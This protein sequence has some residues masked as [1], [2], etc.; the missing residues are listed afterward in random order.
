MAPSTIAR[1]TWVRPPKLRPGDRVRVIAPAGPVPRGPLEAGVAE[2]A[3]LG[4]VAEFDDSLFDRRLIFAGTDARRR[5][6]CERAFADPEARAVFAARGGGGTARI[7]P[8]DAL[9]ALRDRPRAFSGF[10]DLTILHQAMAA[11][12]LVS[13]YGPMVAWD[14]ARAEGAAG[15]Y[16]EALFRRLLLD[17]EPGGPIAPAGIEFL[18]GGAAEGRLAGGCLS[19]L[20][21][22]VGTP[23]SPVFDGAVVVLE[24]ENEYPHRVDRFLHHLRRAGAFRGACA[25]ILGDFPGCEP[26]PGTGMT[27][28]DVLLDFFADFEGPVAWGF[29]I[30]HTPRP[31]L[32]IPL[33]TRARLDD[34]P[35]ALDL[36]EAACV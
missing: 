5:A 23:E 16:D 32:T 28:R 7:L 20:S 27:V 33:G 26:K 18:R 1:E 30:G 6:E 29:P 4:L 36:L 31:N 24:D 13:F 2:L 10:S 34:G 15:G 8:I 14:M 11:R 25:V 21:A 22:C 12:R 3:R 19:L 9:D 17:G 35:G